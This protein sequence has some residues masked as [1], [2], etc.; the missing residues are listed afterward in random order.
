MTWER[1]ISED[2]TG[3]CENCYIGGVKDHFLQVH[4]YNNIDTFFIR[5]VRDG[6]VRIKT[7][8]KVNNLDEAKAVIVYKTLKSLHDTARSYDKMYEQM[9]DSIGYARPEKE[10]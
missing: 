5:Y 9:C 6:L 10:D 2:G 7:T 4:Q 1:T 3:Y 8:T